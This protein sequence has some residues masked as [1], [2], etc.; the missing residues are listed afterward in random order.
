MAF[1]CD[2]CWVV[3]RFGI[4]LGFREDLDVAAV[5][6]VFEDVV[7]VLTLISTSWKRLGV[8]VSGWVG[9]C[10]IEKSCSR[11][12][13]EEEEEEVEFVSDEDEQWWGF[14]GFTGGGGE[15]WWE[16]ERSSDY[17][18]GA[19]GRQHSASHCHGACTRMQGLYNNCPW[20]TTSKQKQ[21]VLLLLHGV[22]FLS[23][24][25]LWA[26][27]NA[28]CN[29]LFLEMRWTIFLL[30][31]ICHD[32][33]T[34]QSKQRSFYAMQG[35]YGFETIT[36]EVGARDFLQAWELE[37]FQPIFVLWGKQEREIDVC[38]WEPE[39]F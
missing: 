18:G 7:L 14:C 19:S 38:A 13:E 15:E 22:S 16:R 39:F 28:F 12:E 17:A 20:W 10:S 4:F 34:H 27:F 29:K 31:T 6:V 1:W 9:L 37:F 5:V 35:V 33:F 32:S 24:L 25:W 23:G 8:A 3:F 30:Q 36:Q 2:S 26:L 21:F 11:E